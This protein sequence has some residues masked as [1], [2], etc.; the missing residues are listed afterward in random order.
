MNEKT[1]GNYAYKFTNF[2]HF[3]ANGYDGLEKNSK[4]IPP[5]STDL[6]SPL[7]INDSEVFY[8]AL[9]ILSI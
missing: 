6:S 2:A 4:K 8:V 7:L 3:L 1:L 5:F 9:I